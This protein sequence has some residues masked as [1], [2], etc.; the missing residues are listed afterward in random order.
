MAD[1]KNPSTLDDLVKELSRPQNVPP[2]APASRPPV[3]GPSQSAPPLRPMSAPPINRPDSQVSRPG[4]PLPQHGTGNPVKEYQS[5]IRTMSDDLSSIKSGQKVAGTD[6]PRK[7]ESSA[8][9]VP[10]PPP[11]GGPP[12][13]QQPPM[14]ENRPS[15]NLGQAQRAQNLN[16]VPPPR[17]FTPPPMSTHPSIKPLTEAPKP[18]SEMPISPSNNGSSSSRFLKPLLLIL[19]LIIVGSALYWYF[20]INDSGDVALSPTPAPTETFSPTPTPIVNDIEALFPTTGGSINLPETG[21]G[22]AALAAAANSQFSVMPGLLTKIS[23]NMIEDG[24][25]IS[26]SVPQLLDKFN[27]KP[28]ELM[29]QFGENS[30]VLVYGQKEAFDSKGQVMLNA[31]PSRRLVLVAELSPASTVS[32]PFMAW[33]KTIVNDLSTIFGIDRSK[34]KGNFLDNSYLGTPIRYKNFSYPDRSIDYGIVTTLSGKKYLIIT[35]SREAMFEVLD[36]FRTR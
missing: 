18:M 5:S 6:I 1:D 14:S 33:E 27:I 32:V 3:P 26:V 9:P 24:Q 15:V 19:A 34:S 23:V 8:R 11:A 35:S 2:P 25:N 12:R 10:P 16:N 29:N 22:K 20:I 13:A 7:I 31:S 4:Q 28:V 17:P 36:L 21:D 30:A